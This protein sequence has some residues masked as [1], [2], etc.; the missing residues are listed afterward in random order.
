MRKALIGVLL[1]VCGCGFHLRGQID[2][3]AQW[4]QIHLHENI[5]DP[6]FVQALHQQFSKLHVEL[7]NNT[8]VPTLNILDYGITEDVL[9]YSANAEPERIRFKVTILYEVLDANGKVVHHHDISKARD[10]TVLAGEQTVY[11]N[12]KERRLYEQELQGEAVVELLRQLS[13][14]LKELPAPEQE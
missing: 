14:V 3:P 13:A 5:P 2:F 11:S 7:T 1:L 12:T 9:A 10:L 6:F 8:N 4:P